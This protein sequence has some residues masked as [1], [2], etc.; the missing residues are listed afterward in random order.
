MSSGLRLQR[1]SGYPEKGTTECVVVILI[2]I[3]KKLPDTN[4]QAMIPKEFVYLYYNIVM[5]A[6]LCTNSALM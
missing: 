3:N 6:S 1:K 4:S 5:C 2:N